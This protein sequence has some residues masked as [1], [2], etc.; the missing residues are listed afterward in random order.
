VC[1]LPQRLR[2]GVPTTQRLSGSIQTDRQ[3]SATRRLES[4][5]F[6]QIRRIPV[7]RWQL[8]GFVAVK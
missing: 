3:Y 6:C 1:G 8:S 2:L 4:I 7:L 5:W